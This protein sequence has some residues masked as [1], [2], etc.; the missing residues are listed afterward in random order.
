MTCLLD[1]IMLEYLCQLFHPYRIGEDKK[2]MVHVSIEI[3]R[4]DIVLLKLWHYSTPMYA[5]AN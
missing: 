2:A 1:V 3:N 5:L 4:L